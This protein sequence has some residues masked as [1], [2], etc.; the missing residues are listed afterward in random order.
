ML[1]LPASVVGAIE[2]NVRG[3]LSTLPLYNMVPERGYPAQFG[4]I[5]NDTNRSCCIRGC[6]RGRGGSGSR[7]RAQGSAGLGISRIRVVLYGVPS[8]HP[9][10]DG[11]PPVGGAPLPFCRIRVIA[12]SLRR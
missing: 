4:F 6:G 9:A 5:F 7:W 11:G 2:L 3:G 8:Q 1:V 12:W 10:P